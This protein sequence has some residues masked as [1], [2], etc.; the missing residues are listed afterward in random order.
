MT[1][2]QAFKLVYEYNW[3]DGVENVLPIIS[4]PSC[5]FATALL[6]YWRLEGPYFFQGGHHPGH[7]HEALLDKLYS[8]LVRGHFQHGG[9]RFDPVR[10]Y[11]LSRVDLH[12]FRKVGLPEEL[13]EPKNS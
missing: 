7:E 12:K 9:A 6:A 5:E 10:E 1:P 8:Q 3:D 2:E 13:V 4:E 11:S